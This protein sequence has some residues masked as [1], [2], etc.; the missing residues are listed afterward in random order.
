[1]IF[2]KTKNVLNV[3]KE[4]KLIIKHKRTFTYK[5]NTRQSSNTINMKYKIKSVTTLNSNH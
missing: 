1:M 3:P 2:Q 4:E 5:N